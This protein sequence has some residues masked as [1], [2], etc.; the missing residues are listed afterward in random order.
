MAQSVE[1]C[2]QGQFL[3]LNKTRMGPRPNFEWTHLKNAFFFKK[4][5]QN[6]VAAKLSQ[7][8]EIV[9]EEKYGFF[10]LACKISAKSVK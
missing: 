5:F 2:I 3:V 8:H 1:I 10:L 6:S 4:K 9:G 7:L